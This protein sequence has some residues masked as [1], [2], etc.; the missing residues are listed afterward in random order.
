LP[1]SFVFCRVGKPD[2]KDT[3]DKKRHRYREEECQES[4]PHQERVTSEGHKEKDDLE[5]GK[6]VDENASSNKP[7]TIVRLGVHPGLLSGSAN[8]PPPLISSDMSLV[9]SDI[10]MASGG[11]RSGP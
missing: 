4:D 11:V 10:G 1:E 6:E 9:F 7:E 8:A 5:E 2:E 3:P